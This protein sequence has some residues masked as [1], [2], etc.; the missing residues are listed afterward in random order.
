MRKEQISIA[1]KS[2]E[3]RQG[4]KEVEQAFDKTGRSARKLGGNVKRLDTQFK[5]TGGAG[6]KLA[7]TMSGLFGALSAGLVIRDAISVIKGFE[8]SMA[9]LRGVTRATETQFE[10]LMEVTRRLGA[11]TRFSAQQAAEG[12]LFLARAGF[13]TEEVIAA[14]PATLHLAQAG[15]LSLGVA[16]DFASNI[17]S[18]FSLDASETVRVVD[19]LII[20]SNRANTN[21]MQLADAMK[22]AGPI[23]GALGISIEET[24]AAIGALGDA[25]IQGTMAGTGLR[26]AMLRLVKPTSEAKK[27]LAEMGIAFENINPEANSLVDIFTQLQRG[28]FTAARAAAIFGARVAGATLILTKNV[29]KIEELIEAQA[30]YKGEAEEMARIMD[31]TM[32]GAFKN[33]RSAIEEMFISFGGGGE[34]GFSG[35]L[36]DMVEI[37]TDVIRVITGMDEVLK[38][39][40]GQIK[41]LAFAVTFLTKALTLWLTLK[42]IVFL[43]GMIKGF[44]TARIAITGVT[45]A[46]WLLRGAMVALMKVG[47]L[48]ALV[49]VWE[50]LSKIKISV[51]QLNTALETGLTKGVKNLKDAWSDFAASMEASDKQ[52]TSKA[53]VKALD[54]RIQA[55]K[56]SVQEIQDQTSFAPTGIMS[57]FGETIEA[58]GLMGSGLEPFLEA[59]LKGFHKEMNGL[60]MDRDD[61][62]REFASSIQQQ[63]NDIGKSLNQDDF[64][65]A[66]A[67]RDEIDVDESVF[68]RMIENL[69]K[70]KKIILDLQKEP[71]TGEAGLEF[72]GGLTSVNLQQAMAATVERLHELGEALADLRAS[73]NQKDFLDAGEFRKSE[74]IM[75]S[76]VQ[77]VEALRHELDG[78]TEEW[79]A[80]TFAQEA[81]N[82]AMKAG[83]FD[84]VQYMNNLNGLLEQQQQL[85]AAIVKQQADMKKIQAIA[86]DA[87]FIFEDFFNS[88]IFGAEKADVAVRNLLESLAQMVFQQVFLQPLAGMLGNILGNLSS[89]LFASLFG[90]GAGSIGT[91][92]SGT[93]NF[94]GFGGSF[95]GGGTHFTAKGAVVDG[96]TGFI[97]PGGELGIMGEAGPEAILPLSRDSQGKLG[98]RGGA[99]TTVVMHIH[100]ITNPDTFR[101]SQR[102]ITNRMGQAVAK[103][104]DQ[105]EQG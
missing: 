79:E 46:M 26:M 90:G 51:N 91:I 74:N 13:D 9:T 80:A 86:D 103:A 67:E 77:T 37:T 64:I 58:F 85:S 102:Q 50:I 94:G 36:R 65:M 68:V 12:A 73:G 25:G 43:S 47:I 15:L 87:S 35:G 33:L 11:T 45:Q 60:I 30:L 53:L 99:S 21:V 20:V 29:D 3:A 31:D 10:S 8:E 59:N 63:L 76:L 52:I 97:T 83:R 96:A 23:A 84:I 27:A 57:F 38:R 4:A 2:R 101:A 22:F 48:L 78:S 49:A 41:A 104:S 71:L 75:S 55:I 7:A 5:K 42:I 6:L 66:I 88:L 54:E 93:G 34:S 16:A 24:A 98:V 14:L 69:Q 18:Q 100:G 95:T 19:D 92:G 44:I 70:Q 32:V 82:T 61:I 62:I 28:G 56:D 40:R 72:F 105:I 89:S 39:N 17:L 1:I 81:Y